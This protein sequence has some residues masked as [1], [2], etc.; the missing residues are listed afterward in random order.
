MTNAIIRLL[1]A[2]SAVFLLSLALPAQA[3]YGGGGS[4]QQTVYDPCQG[5]MDMD[6]C[7][8]STATLN[9]PSATRCV[10]QGSLNQGCRDCKDAYNRLG[11]PLNYKVCAYVTTS[12]GCGCYNENTPTCSY[13]GSCQYN[14]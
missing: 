4:D 5:S 14:S 13:Y 7:F 8:D 1:M 11:Q 9:P 10:A 3:Q 12:A 6:T 2:A